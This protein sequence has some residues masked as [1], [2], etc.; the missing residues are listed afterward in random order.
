VR[1]LRP[2]LTGFLFATLAF[3]AAGCGGTKAAPIP[4]GSSSTPTTTAATTAPP[5][6]PAPAATADPKPKI[7]KP[8]GPPPKKLKI[9]D[10][11]KGR[12]PPVKSGDQ[13]TVQYVGVL[14]KTGQQFDAS[15][16]TG[17]P[18][19]F[20][21][22]AGSVIPGWD[23]GVVGMRAGG[24]RQL[25]IPPALAYGSQGSPPKIPPNSTLI[26]DIDLVKVG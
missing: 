14:Y 21:L 23:K 26:F 12:G 4:G 17:Q 18:F 10:L 20:Q 8:S 24:R 9:I 19:P 13:V 11:K 15:Y 3:A 6:T 2:L 1:S 5:T 7:A 25:I 22:G 16:D